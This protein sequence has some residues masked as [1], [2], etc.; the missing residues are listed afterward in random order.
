M[1]TCVWRYQFIKFMRFSMHHHHHSMHKRCVIGIDEIPPTHYWALITISRYIRFP[2][3]SYV[4]DSGWK[5]SKMS[6][7]TTFKFGVRPLMS[8]AFKSVHIRFLLSDCSKSNLTTSLCPL[9]QAFI[10]WVFPLLSL[11]LK[12][13]FLAKLQALLRVYFCHMS[14]TVVMTHVMNVLRSD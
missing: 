9:V 10:N 1:C 12:S 3:V 5:L 11:V 13:I 14:I 7:F 2:I 8:L 6:H 4:K